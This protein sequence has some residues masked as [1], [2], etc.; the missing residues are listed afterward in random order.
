MKKVKNFLGKVEEVK[1][2]KTWKSS[3]DAPPTQLAYVTQ[4]EIDML[5]KANIHGSM[6]GK[7]NIGPEG[8][9]SLDGLAEEDKA[10][11][12]AVDKSGNEAAIDNYFTNTGGGGNDNNNTADNII[13]NVF[14]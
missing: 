9:L 6:K 10:Y 11:D 7:P 2:P 8:I 1:A 13:N 5:V 4:P 12:D 3:P 14:S